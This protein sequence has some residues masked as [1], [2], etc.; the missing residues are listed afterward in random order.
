[1]EDIAEEALAAGKVSQDDYDSVRG[2]ELLVA[3]QL[4]P[5]CTLREFEAPF[6][7]LPSASLL[8][9]VPRYPDGPYQIHRFA[10]FG[11]QPEK[12]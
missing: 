9:T 3:L 11:F 7:F 5:R 12:I 8:A 6:L 1:M 4:V 10:S 2:A